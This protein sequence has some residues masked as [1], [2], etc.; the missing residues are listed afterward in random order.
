MTLIV[1]C[2]GV[3]QCACTTDIKQLWEKMD[4]VQDSVA[5]NNASSQG[6]LNSVNFNTKTPSLIP[7]SS[8]I[9]SLLAVLQSK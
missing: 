1:L 7:S 9:I 8:T 4:R 5:A 2:I 6:R 3:G